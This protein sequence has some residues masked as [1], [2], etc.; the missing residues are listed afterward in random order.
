L[1]QYEQGLLD[2]DAPAQEYVPELGEI[3]VLAG[4]DRH[5]QPI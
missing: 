3:R 5:D 4:F 2:L 1:Q